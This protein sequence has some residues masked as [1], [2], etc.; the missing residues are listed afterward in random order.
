[1]QDPLGISAV[2]AA[3]GL[4][5]SPVVLIILADRYYTALV[6][7]VAGHLGARTGLTTTETTDL[8][9]AVDEA[10]GLLMPSSTLEGE[11]RCLFVQDESGL[12]MTFSTADTGQGH[13]ETSGFGWRVL[14]ALVDGLSWSRAAGQVRVDIRKRPLERDVF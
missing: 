5:P 7:A 12:Q 14:S 9:L 6:R 8:R 4:G 2:D 1:M 13:P 11:V 3:G 10:Y